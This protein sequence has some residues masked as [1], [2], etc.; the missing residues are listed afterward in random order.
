MNDKRIFRTRVD[1]QIRISPILLIAENG[2]KLGVKNLEEA[3]RM[4]REAGLNLV[5]IAPTARPPVCRIMDYGKF[6]YDESVKDKENRKKQKSTQV[7][8]IR[9]S[10]T[11]GEHDV[12]TKINAARNFLE[13]GM[14]V[15]L[16]LKFEKR[17]MAHKD[18]GYA[19]VKRF[20]ETLVEF[21]APAISPKM[22][23]VCIVCTLEPKK[24]E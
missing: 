12:T 22:E 16:R 2:D 10:P 4:A 5:E 24:H 23:G 15:Q 20:L 7:K 8:E 21:G 19:V 6:K 14:R 11:I 3:K 18:I 17:E 1:D 13:S 9:L